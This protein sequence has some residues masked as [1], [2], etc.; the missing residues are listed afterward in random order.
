M[1]SA[2]APFWPT[3]LAAACAPCSG[4]GLARFAYVPLFPAM[5]AAGWV[6]GAGAGLLGA[7]NLAGYLIGVLAARR[8]GMA[9]GTARTLDLGLLLVVASFAMCGVQGGLWWFV[10]WRLLAGVAG[11]LLMGLAGPATQASVAPER[12][13]MAGGIVIGGVGA[14]VSIA[15]IA[16]PLLVPLGVQV[17]WFGLAGLVLCLWL[18]AH[19]R[20]PSAPVGPA[21][22]PGQARPKAANMIL[23]YGLSGGGLVPPMIYM[24][25]MAVRGRGLP[26]EWASGVWLLFGLGGIVGTLSA[27]TVVDK[28]GGARSYRLWLV[29]QVAALALC[30][31]ASPWLLVPAAIL[32]GFVAMGVTAVVLTL[33]RERA[34]AAAGAVWSRTTACFAIIQAVVAF[35]L[36]Q[37]FAATG[38]SHLA[39][40]SA[41]LALSVVALG[42]QLAERR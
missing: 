19:P 7:A 17:A 42:V 35:A 16:V 34:G 33:A 38:E 15:A 13:G 6:D 14:G 27:G 36:A 2:P 37:V 9:I 40:F 21:A 5:V 25:D 11:G 18:F 41:G 22:E 32:C 31:P 4:I 24:A 10:P 3:A 26:L 29:L 1:T 23:A 39:V 30:L 28:L 8:V 12:R 20:W